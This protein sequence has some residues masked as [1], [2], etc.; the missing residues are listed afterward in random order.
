MSNSNKIATVLF[1]FIFFPFLLIQF[2]S[3]HFFKN[4]C[5]YRYIMKKN[6]EYMYYISINNKQQIV[7]AIAPSIDFD[8]SETILTSYYRVRLSSTKSDYT[9]IYIYT[10]TYM[11][12]CMLLHI[13]IYLY[14]YECI[15]IRML[16]KTY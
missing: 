14:V 1:L 2:D 13:N 16:F 4:K 3:K 8:C 10:Y 9:Y 15:W 12:I 11:Y 6:N 5:I 7:L